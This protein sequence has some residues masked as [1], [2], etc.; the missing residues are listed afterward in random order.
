M[1]MLSATD[2]ARLIVF[3]STRCRN[4]SIIASTSGFVRM[5]VLVA[6]GSLHVTTKE[7]GVTTFTFVSSRMIMVSGPSYGFRVMDGVST[8]VEAKQVWLWPSQPVTRVQGLRAF[9]VFQ[10]EA[11]AF[12]PL[13]ATMES[14]K[15][16]MRRFLPDLSEFKQH[17]SAGLCACIRD[18]H[19]KELC[20]PGSGCKCEFVCLCD[21]NAF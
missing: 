7:A 11:R 2:H 4:V 3:G 16:A 5:E 8:S 13:E 15:F 12:A 6:P 17:I 14:M 21:E 9:F 19:T 1:L 10:D 18:P 20:E